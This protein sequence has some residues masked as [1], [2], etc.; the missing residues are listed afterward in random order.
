MKKRKKRK[1]IVQ[2]W[3]R[4]FA[5]GRNDSREH[6]LHRYIAIPHD[7]LG[8]A[9]TRARGET[10]GRCYENV[11]YDPRA[12]F[13]FH[14]HGARVLSLDGPRTEDRPGLPRGREGKRGLRG[15]KSSH[16]LWRGGRGRLGGK[17]RCY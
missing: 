15:G 12:N 9:L 8:H 14:E 5:R 1:L 11:V 7:H 3:R 16:E 13:N 4:S 17:P 6:R 2:T 10:A